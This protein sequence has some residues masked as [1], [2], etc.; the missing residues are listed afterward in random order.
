MQTGTHKVQRL[1]LA[2]LAGGIV[3]ASVARA[4]PPVVNEEARELARTVFTQMDKDGSGSASRDEA[5][6]F[7]DLVFVSMDVDTD[8]SV[9]SDEFETWS[10]GFDVIATQEERASEFEAV[11]RL[12]FGLWDRDN[13]GTISAAEHDAAL[14][15]TFDYA[16]L[17]AD[18]EMTEDEFLLGYLPNIA[19]RAAVWGQ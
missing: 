18:G 7:S 13:D 3:T 15:G 12:V 8:E 9:S 19:Y 5:Q 17:D 14:G 6:A 10:F 16:D 4:E 2:L 1:G 11:D